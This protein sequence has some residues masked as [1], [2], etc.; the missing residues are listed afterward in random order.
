MKKLVCI[1]A[2]LALIFSMTVTSFA[3]VEVNLNNGLVDVN[4]LL[5]VEDEVAYI[6][7]R[8]AFNANAGTFV[9]ENGNKQE[10]YGKN[11]YYAIRIADD[12]ANNNVEISMKRKDENGNV[13]NEGKYV[14]INW[15]EG[16]SY[17]E[18]IRYKETESGPDMEDYY[19]DYDFQ[20][21]DGKCKLVPVNET[22]DRLFL[23]LT[24]MQKIIDFLTGGD[25]YEVV[26]E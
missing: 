26:I 18:F 19:D 25:N 20:N 15:T 17:L 21:W 3:A 4:K 16:D 24:D 6:P 5:I 14:K 9:D 12:I 13:I 22:G 7:L 10:S 23:P 8:I 1:C 2:A 11:P